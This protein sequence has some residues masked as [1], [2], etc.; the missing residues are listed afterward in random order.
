MM[1][2]LAIGTICAG[3]SLGSMIP[4]SVVLIFYGLTAQVAIGD[5]FI[6]VIVPESP[7]S[8]SLHGLYYHSL[9]HKPEI[10]ASVPIE[11]RNM[12]FAQKLG[13]IKNLILP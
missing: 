3:G 11:Q 6:A 5:L 8:W 12:S 7:F 4:P 1:E 9:S 13:L 2:N 10:A